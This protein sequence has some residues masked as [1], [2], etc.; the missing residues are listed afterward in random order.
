[1]GNACSVDSC[2][3]TSFLWQM[4]INIS[5]PDN[6]T[7]ENKSALHE[8]IWADELYQKLC[9][10]KLWNGTHWGSW[11]SVKWFTSTTWERACLESYIENPHACQCPGV[12]SSEPIN[13]QISQNPWLVGWILTSLSL[14]I[15]M[16]EHYWP[17][18]QKVSWS[19]E[20]IENPAEQTWLKT[21]NLFT[22]GE[23]FFEV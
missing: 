7:L 1:M 14:A 20:T 21:G 3:L 16:M 5:V 19:M 22:C 8:S 11:W 6:H 9:S 18:A 12:P 23:L 10:F 4:L 2:K 15:L 17:S 13:V